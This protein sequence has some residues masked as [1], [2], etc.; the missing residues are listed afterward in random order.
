MKIDNRIRITLKLL[1]NEKKKSIPQSMMIHSSNAKS[2]L[3]WTSRAK[4]NE[5]IRIAPTISDIFL[6]DFM[7]EI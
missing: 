1:L 6:T 2:L 3:F 4:K 7:I 5:T